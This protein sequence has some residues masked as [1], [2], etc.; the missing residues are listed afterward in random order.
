MSQKINIF[1]K[2]IVYK[3]YIKYFRDSIINKILIAF[4]H[5]IILYLVKNYFIIGRLTGLER[6]ST[7]PLC[8]QASTTDPENAVNAIIGGNFV[9]RFSYYKL[10][11][12]IVASTPFILGIS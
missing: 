4:Y 2:E 7:I 10:N 1:L 6:I 9:I 5:S 8:K 3:H 11:N 12:S